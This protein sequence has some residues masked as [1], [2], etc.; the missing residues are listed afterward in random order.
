MLPPRPVSLEPSQELQKT[1]HLAVLEKKP[2]WEARRVL[3]PGNR[4]SQILNPGKR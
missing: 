1:E 3:P 2:G 4:V